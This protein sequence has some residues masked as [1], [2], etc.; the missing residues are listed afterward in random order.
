MRGRIGKHTSYKWGEKGI[1][2]DKEGKG[3]EDGW[4]GTTTTHHTLAKTHSRKKTGGLKGRKE[5]EKI[6]CQN[7]IFNQIYEHD[8]NIILDLDLIPPF[9]VPGGNLQ[10]PLIKRGNQEVNQKPKKKVRVYYIYSLE[11]ILD[12]GEVRQG[13]KQSNKRGVTVVRKFVKEGINRYTSS[14]ARWVSIVCW[15]GV[16]IQNDG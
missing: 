5:E 16:D 10:V 6:S 8:K 12:K 14:K 9:I 13:R 3:R 1:R 4:I 2:Q 15:I 11:S 7:R